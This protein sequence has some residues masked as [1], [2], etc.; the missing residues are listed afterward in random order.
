L[1]CCVAF[2]LLLFVCCVWDLFVVSFFALQTNINDWSS[3]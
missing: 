1:V 2:V 3:E